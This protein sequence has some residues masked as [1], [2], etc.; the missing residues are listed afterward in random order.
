M[1]G[2]DFPEPETLIGVLSEVAWRAQTELGEREIPGDVLEQWLLAALAEDPEWTGKRR[3][4]FFEA[5]RATLV[6]VLPGVDAI[7]TN[8]DGQVWIDGPKVGKAPLAAMSDGYV[9]TVGWIVDLVARWAER[10]HRLGVE[11]DGDFREEM[12]GL[13]LIDQID[14]HLHPLWQVGIVSDLRL[15]RGGHEA[16]LAAFDVVRRRAISR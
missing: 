10:S 16:L 12:T 2:L 15:G 14:L 13:V 11:L 3:R 1:S 5:L 4:A 8:R 6:E 9:T 7:D